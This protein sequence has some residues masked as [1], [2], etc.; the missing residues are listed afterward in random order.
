VSDQVAWKASARASCAAELDGCAAAILSLLETQGPRPVAG[1]ASDLGVPA[2]AIVS[3]LVQL[4][5]EGLVIEVQSAADA[6]CEVAML[7][8]RGRLVASGAA[9][10]AGNGSQRAP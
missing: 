4:V 9:R 5:R 1:L 3:A 2:G 7:S 6:R 8:T 10:S